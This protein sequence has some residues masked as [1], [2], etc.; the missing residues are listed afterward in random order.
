MSYMFPHS[1]VFV[2]QKGLLEV[3]YEIFRLPVP[4]VTNEFEE[5]LHSI[6]ERFSLP[7][8][9]LNKRI[10]SAEVWVT[11]FVCCLLIA[12][13]SH[14][15]P[16]T[17]PSRFQDCW[18]LSDGFVAAE[19]KVVL[20]HRAR[21]RWDPRLKTHW[22]WSYWRIVF[23][24]SDLSFLYSRPDLMDNYLALVLSAFITSGLLE[25]CRRF[26]N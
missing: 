11:L 21:S 7:C 15:S 13:Y 22:Y 16:L 2:L 1:C 4:I 17:D 20:P 23:K 10:Q 14:F 3:L 18:R 25:V 26:H 19:A 6:G 8:L 5:A 24:L 12:L 9:L